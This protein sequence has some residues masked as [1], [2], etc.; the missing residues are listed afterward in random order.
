[1]VNYNPKPIP[2]VKK[3]PK[4]TEQQKLF[5][6]EFLV[7][8]NATQAALRAG[9][10]AKYAYSMGSRNLQNE[11]V[12][13]YLQQLRADAMKRNRISQ[14]ELMQDLIEIKNRCLQNVPVMYYDKVDKEWKHEGLEEGEPVYKFDSQGATK[15]LDLLCKIVGAYE[16]DNK[17]RALVN[18]D[19]KIEVNKV[20]FEEVRRDTG[21][22]FDT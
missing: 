16:K 19:V 1:M 14:D 18:T 9:Y 6:Q 13:E 5:C 4:L 21:D 2:V 11:R 3:E 22:I 12:Q 10:G 8:L 20:D 15:A 7:D 17:Q